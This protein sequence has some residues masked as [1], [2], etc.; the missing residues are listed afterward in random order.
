[1]P[2]RERPPPPPIRP[3]V[4]VCF[5]VVFSN[6]WIC[7]LPYLT[8]WSPWRD[9]VSMDFHALAPSAHTLHAITTM[10]AVIPFEQGVHEPW[11]LWTGTVVHFWFPH[12]LANMM[13]L[14]MLGAP[15]ERLRGGRFWLAIYLAA[16]AAGSLWSSLTLESV[17]VGASGAVFGVAGALLVSLIRMRRGF[18]ASTASFVFGVSFLAVLIAANLFVG[19]W[20]SSRGFAFH[21]DHRAHLGGLVAGMVLAALPLPG[22]VPGARWW[23]A[24]LLTVFL[25]ACAIP[26]LRVLV[27]EP[28]GEPMEITELGVELE[29]PSG[30]RASLRTPQ[31]WTRVNGEALGW[32]LHDLASR[33]L[34]ARGSD[35]E[36][37][38][39]A[40][41]ESGELGGW[42][43]LD[44]R[45]LMGQGP[46][47]MLY[48]YELKA[49]GRAR[50]LRIYRFAECQVGCLLVWLRTGAEPDDLERGVNLL[51][52]LRRR[53]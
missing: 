3:P 16:G 39:D 30:W 42:R 23:G 28:E 35:L 6:V 15:L 26:I 29:L 40:Q 8:G 14:M 7:L 49:H 51:E 31:L 36:A 1:M 45:D 46:G 47:G 12:L 17:S 9:L 5:L 24:A 43:Q 50:E 25:S 52:G 27:G 33:S 41:V 38:F 21:I 32:Q 4:R 13:V 44:Q 2:G 34:L 37:R 19:Y 18:R 11:R 53:R 10:G 48:A 20:L 22:R